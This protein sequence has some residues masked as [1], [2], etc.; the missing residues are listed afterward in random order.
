MHV[1]SRTRTLGR[2]FAVWLLLWFLVMGANP[3]VPSLAVQ[4]C[5]Q[6]SGEHGNEHAHHGGEEAHALHAGGGCIDANVGTED[7]GHDGHSAGSSLHCAL[8]L[9][10]GAPPPAWDPGLA[11]CPAPSSV[12]VVPREPRCGSRPF[13]LPPARGPPALS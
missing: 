10:A 4:A 3:V 13:P 5:V 11:K 6:P 7:S 12:H 1:P 8:C 2:C 9:H